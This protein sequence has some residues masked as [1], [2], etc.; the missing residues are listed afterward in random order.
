MNTFMWIELRP[1]TEQLVRE[2]IRNG[3]FHSIDELIVQ[4]VQALREKT[5]AQLADNASGTAADAV[6]RLRLLR[7]GVTLGGLKIK[8]LSR[9]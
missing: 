5:S 8:D 2:E 6:A 7:N 9:R 4:G 3:R 1:E